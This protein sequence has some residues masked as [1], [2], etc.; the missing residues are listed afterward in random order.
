MEKFYCVVSHTH[1]DREWYQ[2]FEVFRRQLVDLL[3]H[4]QAIVERYPQYIFHLD[5]QTVVLEDYLE[6]RPHRRERLRELVRRG[7]L[8]VGPWYL[9]NDFYLTSG[10]AT[11]RNLLEGSHLADEFGAC[12]RVGYAPDQ[13]GNISQLPQILR[14]FGIDSF[15]FG[16]GYDAYEKDTDGNLRRRSLPAEF[17]WTGADGSQVLAVHLKYWYNNAQRFSEDM[18]RAKGMVEKIERDFEGLTATPYLLLMNGVDHLEAQG[19]L[20]PVLDALNSRGINGRIRQVRLEDYI[21]EVRRF[22]ER[23]GTFLPGYAGELRRGDDGSLLKGTYSSRVYLKRANVLAQDMLECRL[24]PLYAMLEAAGFRGVYDTDWFR[25]MWKRLMQNHPHDSI[26]GCSRDEIHRHM[27]DRYACLQELS[28]AWLSKG[29]QTAADHNPVTAGQTEGY[30]LVAANTM[31]AARGGV[32]EAVLL[33]PASDGVDGFEIVDGNGR[34][35]DFAVISREAVCH[36]VFSPVN[37]PGNLP[38]ERCRVYLRVPEVPSMAFKGFAVRPCRE[39][40]PEVKRLQGG[41]PPVLENECLRVSVTPEGRIAIEDKRSGRYIADA[42]YWEDTADRG[43]A[44]IYYPGGEPPLLSA[45]LRPVVTMLEKNRF[46]ARC[47]IKWDMELPAA[48]DFEKLCRSEETVVS[49]LTVE[50][51]LRSGSDVLE[52]AYEVDNRAKDHRLRL[53]VSSDT[54]KGTFLTDIPFD[55]LTHTEEEFYAFTRSR[56]TVSSS[57]AALE[58]GVRGLAVMTEGLHECENVEEGLA[59]TVLRANGV[60]NRKNGTTAAGGETWLCPENQCL[61]RL[62]GRIGIHFYEGDAR[63]SELPQKARM[64]RNPLLIAFAPCDKT[65]FTGGRPAVQETE[66]AELFYLPDPYERVCFP[67]GRP[68]LN[69]Q[70]SELLVS[71][72]KKAESGQGYIVRVFHYGGAEQTISLQIQGDIYLSDMAERGRQYLGTDSVCLTVG[73]KAIRT[74]WITGGWEAGQICRDYAEGSQV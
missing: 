31:G 20:L 7:N 43:D 41:E 5:A 35:V 59:F 16:R 67:D 12:S 49:Y 21:H 70:G 64:F 28:A 2:P 26:C 47:R 18:N 53:I 56:T 50:L 58:D 10:E 9:Q 60:I 48:Y 62:K 54:E 61:R 6:I 63:A 33:F 71:A 44:Y 52:A 25:Y 13:F 65:R 1:W 15:V 36:D 72:F 3:D 46:A 68:L 55:I 69:V 4:L 29:L 74:F 38:V 30:S 37:L 24:E 8:I 42:L 45:G 51:T 22:I 11:V 73:P 19:N 23:Q 40:A 39:A 66:L 57:W 14:D 27:E 34:H 32:E 17:I